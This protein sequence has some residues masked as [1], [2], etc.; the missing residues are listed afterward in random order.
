MRQ[1]GR[2][3]VETH[4][5]RLY[6]Q[7]P[8][9]RI[10]LRYEL[11]QKI[12]LQTQPQNETRTCSGYWKNNSWKFRKLVTLSLFPISCNDT[13]TIIYF[14]FDICRSWQGANTSSMK[15]RLVVISNRNSPFRRN[16]RKY[17]VVGCF[18]TRQKHS[19]LQLQLQIKRR[20]VT[21]QRIHAKK[22]FE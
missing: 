9:K 14:L 18:V 5:I 6:F 7:L 10:Q 20:V 17:K 11:G 3:N 12:L 19:I 16:P 15:N 8:K 1:L 4:Y 22:S 2:Y 21:F 13:A